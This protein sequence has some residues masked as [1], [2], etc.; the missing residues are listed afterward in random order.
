MTTTTA[1]ANRNELT[2]RD[3]GGTRTHGALRL[4]SRQGV[5][6]QSSHAAKLDSGKER[7]ERNGSGDLPSANGRNAILAE[8]TGEPAFSALFDTLLADHEAEAEYQTFLAEVETEHLNR[9]DEEDVEHWGAKVIAFGANPVF[10]MG[11]AA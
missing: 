10:G 5:G 8:V 2:C 4:E 3:K 11:V 7:T 1:D 6:G 9:Q